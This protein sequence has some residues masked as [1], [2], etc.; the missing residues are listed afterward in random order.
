MVM[1]KLVDIQPKYGRRFLSAKSMEFARNKHLT[2]IFHPKK[3]RI[4]R[5]FPGLQRI[6]KDALREDDQKQTNKS[7]TRRYQPNSKNG[8][9]VPSE[10][11]IQQKFSHLKRELELNVKRPLTK[12]NQDE[13]NTE[14]NQKKE[15]AFHERTQT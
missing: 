13:T 12:V 8:H 4:Y 14:E 3:N 5:S 15:I 7:I 6:T 2:F 10:R 1:K 11:Q 9:N